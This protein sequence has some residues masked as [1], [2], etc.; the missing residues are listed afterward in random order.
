[1]PILG[2]H[3]KRDEDDGITRGLLDG[4]TDPETCKAMHG[5]WDKRSGRCHAQFEKKADKPKEIK[6]IDFDEYITPGEEGGV[7]SGND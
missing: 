5:H 7:K 6:F 2:G 1:M 4:V 3:K